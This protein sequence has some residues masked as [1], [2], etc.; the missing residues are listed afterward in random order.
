MS[1]LTRGQRALSQFNLHSNIQR[2][3]HPRLPSTIPR[4]FS[5]SAASHAAKQGSTTVTTPP[6]TQINA[7]AS[8][9]PA[10]LDLPT[11]LPA[12]AQTADKLKRLVTIGRAYL[13]FYK[14]GLKNV[15]RNYRA[16]LPLRAS[17]GLPAY[18]PISPPRKSSNDSTHKG[19]NMGRGQY[20]LVV[21]SARDVRKMIPFTLVL[22]ICG[23]FTP[24]IIPLFGSA[25]TPATCRVP[26]Q[27]AKERDGASKRKNAAMRAQARAIEPEMLN[28]VSVG[29]EEEMRVLAEFASPRWVKAAD[30]DAVLR[31]CAVFGLV[32]SHERAGGRA[33]VGLLYRARLERYVEYLGIDDG[34]IR[35][36]GG[37]SRL[38]A[39]EV[40]IAL[41]ERGAGDVAALYTGAKAERAE[42]K[43]LERWLDVR[44][45]EVKSRT[46]KSR[47]L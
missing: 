19:I 43:W 42:R 2:Q 7:P 20:Q 6:P 39:D 18:I 3:F 28:S 4:L 40:R 10:P 35:A 8:T 14:T 23:E 26:G 47:V 1:S 9:L 21:R 46:G 5:T 15:Y 33:L 25:I 44:E 12:N 27:V 36:G 37:V 17:L 45:G 13:A 38:S 30:K 32:K 16:S 11:V 22:I 34:M 41:D 31:A 24:L 29:S